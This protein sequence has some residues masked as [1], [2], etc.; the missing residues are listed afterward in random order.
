[1]A[2]IVTPTPKRLIQRLDQGRHRRA[3]VFAA[4][5]A[6]LPLEGEDSLVCWGDLQDIS[7][8]TEGLPEELET[9][10]DMRDRCLLLG[11]GQTALCK[12]PNDNGFDLCFQQVLRFAGDDK[13]I[14]IM[15]ERGVQS[16]TV[17]VKSMDGGIAIRSA[18]PQKLGG[19]RSMV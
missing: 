1:M 3:D 14:R 13:V 19:I 5:V 6:H 12:E 7:N 4:Q 16:A 2:V 9:V 15:S 11:E 17:V 10:L 8:L 18:I